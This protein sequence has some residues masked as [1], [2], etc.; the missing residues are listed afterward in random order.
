MVREIQ[1]RSALTELK[2][3]Y[4]FKKREISFVHGL[5]TK[6]I[7]YAIINIRR[8]QSKEI[9]TNEKNYI[10]FIINNNDI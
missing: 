7:A 8:I 6:N 10:N 1:I 2:L 9:F 3:I 4:V 5:L